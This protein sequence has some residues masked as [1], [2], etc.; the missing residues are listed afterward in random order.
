MF[1]V[2]N[3]VINWKKEKV[4]LIHDFENVQFLKEN[5][6]RAVVHDSNQCEKRKH[7]YP[8]TMMEM[9]TAIKQ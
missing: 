4:I 1:V 9:T 7:L 6:N 8:R 2:Y 5:S 3:V